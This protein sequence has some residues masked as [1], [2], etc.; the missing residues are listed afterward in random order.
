MKIL[1]VGS[2]GVGGFYGA[3]LV[4]AGHEVTF[5][6]RGAHLKA[7]QESGLHI[8]NDSGHSLSLPS[9]NAVGDLR[10]VNHPDL[11]LIAVKLWDLDDVA[12]SL[13]DIVGTSAT[14][15]SLQNG[16]VKDVA[17]KRLFGDTAV[18]G[19]VGYV[20]T[21][22]DRPGVIK[23]VGGLQ[24]IRLGA[25]GGTQSS[26]VSELAESLERVGIDAQVSDD[27]QRVLWEK[28]VFLVGLSAMTCLTRLPIG[29]IREDRSTRQMLHRVIAEAVEVGLAQMVA[30]PPD[31]AAQSMDLVDRLPFTMTSSMFH[32]LE[33][34]NRLELPW[35][36]GGVVTLAKE[37]G[38]P[39][40]TNQFI[41]DALSPHVM[42][43]NWNGTPSTHVAPRE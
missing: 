37:I 11:V 1:I 34:G 22:L 42:G 6:A 16:V 2:G 31:Y 13:K 20:A 43:I 29:P 38:A 19:G 28:F 14:I 8:E 27:I 5:L 32:D 9:V 3:K 18:I 40:P 39:A 4:Q 12:A 33:K 41:A 30:L 26:L 15:L 24:K 7:M 23:Q 17:L 10:A 36:S 25:Y 21:S 35:L